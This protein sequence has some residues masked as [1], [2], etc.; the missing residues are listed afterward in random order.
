[1]IIVKDVMIY[2]QHTGERMAVAAAGQ[3]PG[4]GGGAA[5][6]VFTKQTQ[7]GETNPVSRHGSGWRAVKP[8]QARI[9]DELP[10][11]TNRGW[12]VALI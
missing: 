11:G 3:L 1:M 8:P 12:C 5:G 10:S 4:G 9:G 6:G 7:F 2:H